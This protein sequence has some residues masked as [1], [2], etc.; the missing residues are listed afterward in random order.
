MDPYETASA[1]Q[2]KTEYMAS[3]ILTITI[4]LHQ[5]ATREK[6]FLFFIYDNLNKIIFGMEKNGIPEMED[7]LSKRV[8]FPLK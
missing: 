2:E 6:T 5:I 3:G 8:M 4:P 1:N 7:Y